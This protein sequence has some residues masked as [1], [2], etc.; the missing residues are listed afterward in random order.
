MD[1]DRVA[2]LT[3]MSTTSNWYAGFEITGTLKAAIPHIIPQSA[4]ASLNGVKQS[5]FGQDWMFTPDEEADPN[6]AALFPTNG[7]RWA[8]TSYL[9]VPVPLRGA[10]LQAPACIRFSM[11]SV[12]LKHIGDKIGRHRIQVCHG[13]A[14][15]MIPLK[16]AERLRSELGLEESNFH[17][18]SGD[19]HLV[20][21]SRFKEVAA[22][23][24][25]MIHPE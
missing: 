22:L 3:L 11:S 17:V 20:I 1:G 9:D 10:I 7:D 5:L 19:A 24:E 18:F 16:A 25:Q 21:I 12:Q 13:S 15:R 6:K 8:A 4:D 14:D 23:L 2:S